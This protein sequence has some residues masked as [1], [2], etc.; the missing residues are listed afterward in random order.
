[1]R[2]PDSGEWWRATVEDDTI[3]VEVGEGEE[4]T[5]TTEIDAWEEFSMPAINVLDELAVEQ[6]RLGFELAPIDNVLALIESGHEVTLSGRLRAF[7]ETDEYRD[8]DGKFCQSLECTVDFTA[9]SVLGD[10]YD[11]FYDSETEQWRELIPISAK[12]VDG[13]EDEQAWIGVD[14]EMADGPVYELFTSNAFQEAYGSL[15]DFLAD[16]S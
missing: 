7:F 8:Y 1:M 9:D 4:T 10:F 5:S 13:L 6:S 3:L 14:P 15:D 11:E 12:V 2:N 16:L